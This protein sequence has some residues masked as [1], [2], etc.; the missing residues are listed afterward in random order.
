[1]KSSKKLPISERKRLYGIFIEFKHTKL[2][3]PYEKFCYEYIKRF[4]NYI[5]LIAK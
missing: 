4:G 2:Y 5:T 3:I 1:M